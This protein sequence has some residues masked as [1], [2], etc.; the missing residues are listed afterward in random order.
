MCYDVNYVKTFSVILKME[1]S[2]NNY[3]SPDRPV[4]ILQERIKD[5]NQGFRCEAVNS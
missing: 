2:K 3:V 5:L 1:E 4:I